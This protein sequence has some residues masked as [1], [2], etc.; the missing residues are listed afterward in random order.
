MPKYFGRNIA[1]MKKSQYTS[2]QI[3]FALRQAEA[4][5]HFLLLF[6]SVDIIYAESCGSPK[7]RLTIV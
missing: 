3:V 1:Q 5:T 7:I 6:L 4:G 2:E